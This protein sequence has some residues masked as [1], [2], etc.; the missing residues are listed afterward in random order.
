MKAS[1]PEGR[2]R[3]AISLFESK[4]A[5]SHHDLDGIN[6]GDVPWKHADGTKVSAG[7]ESFIN[8]AVE[9]TQFLGSQDRLPL[10]DGYGAPATPQ[11]GMGELMSGSSNEDTLKALY[12][13]G[14]NEKEAK[15]IVHVD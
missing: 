4:D 13:F 1:E 9:K 12:A 14:F 7:L 11:G 8:K 5:F 15:K 10:R 3:N 2:V 6:L